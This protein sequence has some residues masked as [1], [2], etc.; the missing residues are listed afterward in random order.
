MHVFGIAL[1]G[2]L[3]A[4]C[5]ATTAVPT[6]EDRVENAPDFSAVTSKAAAARLARAGQLVTIPLFPTELG[7]PDDP[8]NIGYITPEAADACEQ[9]IGT[10]RRFAVDG[11]I[12]QMEVEPDYRGTS[13]IRTRIR[14][15][16]WHSKCGSPIEMALEVG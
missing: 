15:K 5:P 7:R 9:I 1:A 11:L 6:Q 12:D 13:H 10:L 2:L 14:F 4:N 16:A 8:A 3:L